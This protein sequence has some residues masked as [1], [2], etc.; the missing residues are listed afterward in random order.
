MQQEIVCVCVSVT[1]TF[2]NKKIMHFRDFFRNAELVN[3]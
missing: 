3:I 1:M 2:C